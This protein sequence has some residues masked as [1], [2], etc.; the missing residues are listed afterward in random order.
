MQDSNEYE[1]VLPDEIK[2]AMQ[3]YISFLTANFAYE[4]GIDE[5]EFKAFRESVTDGIF[6]SGDVPIMERNNKGIT[7]NDFFNAACIMMT[8]ML[9]NATSGNIPQA[10]QVLR[11]MGLAVVADS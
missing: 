7:G 5:V 2:E 6:M 3:I 9:Y 1:V 4:E 8:D 10:Q 11:D